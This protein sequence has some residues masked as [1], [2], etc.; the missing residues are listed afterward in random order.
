V[1]FIKRYIFPGSF[2]PC[3]TVLSQSA[4]K[5]ELRLIDLKDL[6][7]SYATTLREWRHRFLANLEQV[8]EQ[9]YPESFIRMWLFYL[10]YCEGGFIE[11]SISDVHLLFEKP[12]LGTEEPHA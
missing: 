9:G 8:R 11:R 12:L 10:C 7:E 1:D 6:G 3:V 5:S 2:I 4:A